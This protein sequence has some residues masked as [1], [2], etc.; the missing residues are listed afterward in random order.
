MDISGVWRGEYSEISEGHAKLSS[1]SF[2]MKIKPTKIS[3]FLGLGDITFEGVC[4]DDPGESNLSMH[5]TVYGS[6][7]KPDIYFVKQYPKLMID[8]GFGKIETHDEPHPEIYYTGKFS[9]DK[10]FGNWNM[11]RSFRKIKGSVTE[12]SRKEGIWWMSKMESSSI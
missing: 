3:G 12:F 11:N 4:Q 5:A 2:V 1:V 7:N 9:N 6:I 10:F 8:F